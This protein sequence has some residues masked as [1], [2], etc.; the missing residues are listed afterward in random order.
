MTVLRTIALLC[1][2]AMTLHVCA[3]AEERESNLW[4]AVVR[5]FDAAG[6]TEAWSAA[7]PFVFSQPTPSGGRASGLRPVWVQTSDASRD[8]R[9]WYFLYPI[10]SYTT[11]R[12][13]YKWSFFELIRRSDRRA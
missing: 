8:F 6:H 4:P 9:A 13:T 12:S 7:G 5:Q 3:A 2:V 10:F 11:D 1:L